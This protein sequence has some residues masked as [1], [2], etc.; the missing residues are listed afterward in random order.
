MDLFAPVVVDYGSFYTGG[1]GLWIFLHRWWW[2]MDLFAPGVVD[3]GSFCTGWW[4]IMELFA[5][6]GGGFFSL[7]V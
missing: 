4:W 5:P 7:F 2:I 3:Y 6:G 1:G